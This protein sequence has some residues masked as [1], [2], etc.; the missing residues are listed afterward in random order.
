MAAPERPDDPALAR[1]EAE[2]SLFFAC[3]EA[4][5]AER[6]RL[7]AQADP[8]LAGRV[9]HLLSLGDDDDPA[10]LLPAGDALR[11]V[12]PYR[13]MRR[14]GEGGMGEVYLAVQQV[15][16]RRLV[17]VK[18]VRAGAA[19]GEVLARFEAERQALALMAHPGIARM[20]DAGELAPGQPWFAMDY[21]PG[22]GIFEYC[23][24]RRLGLRERLRLLVQVCE[25]VQHAHQKGIIHRDLKPSNILVTETAGRP[26]PVVIDFGVAKALGGQ[27]AVS[28]AHT[29]LGALMGTPDYMSPEQADGDRIDIDTRSDIWSL[30]AIA[31]QLL[32]GATPFRFAQRRTPLRE[33]QHILASGDLPRPSGRLRVAEQEEAGLADPVA[34]RAA[35]REA[36]DWVLLRAMAADRNR[37]YEAASALAADLQRF[38]DDR[39][40]KARPPSLVYVARTALRRHALAATAAAGLVLA[41]AAL[42][43]GLAASAQALRAERDRTRVEAE[44]AQQVTD[45]VTGLFATA[46]PGAGQGQVSAREL[47]DQ[48][49][50]RLRQAPSA[51]PAVQASLLQAAARLYLGFGLYGQAA[52]LAEEALALLPPDDAGGRAGLTLLLGELD[53]QQGELDR[54]RQRIGEARAHYQASQSP[55]EVDGADLDLAEIAIAGGESAGA[56]ALVADV[57]ARLAARTETGTVLHGRALELS[58]RLARVAGDGEA[59][60]RDNRRALEIFSLRLGDGHLRAISA[61]NALGLALR[62]AGR[63]DEAAEVFGRLLATL[64]RDY[65]ED[66]VVTAAAAHNL[67]A[68][69]TRQGDHQG[70]LALYRRAL[71]AVVASKGPDHPDSL[72]V[73][74]GLAWAAYLAAPGQDALA[75]L[76]ATVAA[77]ERAHGAD[78]PLLA[79]SG[80][81][82]AQALLGQGQAA[83]AE[84]QAR[85][86][87]RLLVAQR[88]PA[89]PRSL[90]AAALLGETL[91]AQGRRP[92]DD[93]AVAAALAELP[94]LAGD[95]PLGTRLGALAAP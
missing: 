39:P 9:R 85:R 2:Q 38:L 27:L 87:L 95:D 81:Q 79:G 22:T 74:G 44:R 26:Q 4:T 77:I 82:Y 54:A 41:L 18:L 19:S 11:Q 64:D 72:R 45:F 51:D 71:A 59:A 40:V 76:A 14:I 63:D 47:L 12:G 75:G 89:H 23:R 6:E 65:G 36:L 56:A 52:A 16:V 7:L 55:A 30:G 17:A 68:L 48:A 24:Q 62:E 37:R 43:A 15:P 92:A 73:R 10:A 94:R 83:Q 93:P 57:L 32:T 33:V 21:V 61:A 28:G 66:H 84:V 88:G 3:F 78:S 69:R 35:L 42:V 70:A 50:R 49:T 53:Y 5:P 20:L 25:A 58:A 31:W 34:T 1:L 8:A 67:A 80:E 91:K 29:R 60:V 13:L 90:A 46:D 86:A